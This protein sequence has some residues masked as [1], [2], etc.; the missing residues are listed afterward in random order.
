MKLFNNVF[1]GILPFAAAMFFQTCHSVRSIRP[2]SAE[3]VH[4]HGRNIPCINGKYC[5]PIA[6]SPPF[7]ISRNPYS[8]DGRINYDNFAKA[9]I[10]LV[11]MHIELRNAWNPDGTLNI[12]MVRHELISTLQ[13][14][15]AINPAACFQVRLD[16]HAPLWWLKKYPEEQTG[17]ARGAVDFNA[18]NDIVRAPNASLASE[19]WKREAT[20]ILKQFLD[21]LDTTDVGKRVYSFMAGGGCG[22]E[23]HYFGYRQEPDTG[24]AMTRN[25]RRWLSEKYGTDRALQD[26]WNHPGAT[27]AAATVPDLDE[28]RYHTGVFRDP[29]KE[30]RII[31]YFHCHQETVEEAILHFTRQLRENWP[32]KVLVGLFNGY[33]F[34]DNDFNAN[35]HL[36]FDRLLDSPYIDF[37]AGPYNYSRQARDPG[38]TSQPRSLVESVN[39]HGKLFMTEQDRILH[40][41][42]QSRDHETV[43][44][45]D[46][47][48]IATLRTNFAQ[49]ASRAAG[50]WFEEFSS[51]PGFPPFWGHLPL[52]EVAGNFNS[53]AIMAEIKCQQTFYSE[54][55]HRDYESVADVAFF[56]DFN[57]YYY[58]AECDNPQTR[59]IEHASNNGMISDAFRSG[60]TFDTYL[61][62]DMQR[63]DYSKYRAVVFGTTYCMSNADMDFIDRVIKKDGRTVIF[64]YAPAYTDG[65]R[66]DM[67]RTSK[68]TGMKLRSIQMDTPPMVTVN[69]REYGLSSRSLSTDGSAGSVPVTPLFA[70]DDTQV[71][72]LGYYKDTQISAIARKKHADYTVV[73]A[74]LPLRDPDLIRLLFR[75]AGAHIYNNDNDV[76]IAGGGIV[77]LATKEGESGKRI[78]RL[79][80]G[81]EVETVMKPGSTVILDDRTGNILFD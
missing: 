13:G 79:R 71:E 78:V 54:M 68:I 28:R 48:S 55:I 69:G 17:Y 75:E 3:L 73:Y 22:S 77:C 38:G 37:F 61:F 43:L 44:K 6:Y 81:K 67:D 74:A 27:I 23:W 47:G 9:D 4:Y 26:A 39:L 45:N 56:Y 59:E 34:F 36:Y 57:T 16:I 24:E 33:L 64:T 80:N 50:Y 58:M 31:D 10:D 14:I 21:Y 62:S 42:T 53:P 11:E 5:P 19:R 41:L 15:L 35:G 65:Y 1:W 52:E 72:V 60:A 29:Q 51:F 46:D 30:R 66:L 7:S 32:R 12:P 63:I 25:F 76:I 70:I 49:L 20:Q 18:P 8:E 2:V 40:R